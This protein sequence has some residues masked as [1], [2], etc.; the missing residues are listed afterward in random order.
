MNTTLTA[1]ITSDR[2]L[3]RVLDRLEVAAN[4]GIGQ[5]YVRS[6]ARWELK[7]AILDT[8]RELDKP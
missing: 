2:F 8:L 4:S 1:I 3:D 5:G 6:L 7:A